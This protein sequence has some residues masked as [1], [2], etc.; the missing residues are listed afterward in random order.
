MKCSEE[1]KSAGLK[2]LVQFSE[3]TDMPVTTIR[4]WHK[5]KYKSFCV[6]L[7]GAVCEK[8]HNKG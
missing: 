6:L 1:V 8:L 5:N 3:I 4:D 7:K 2:S